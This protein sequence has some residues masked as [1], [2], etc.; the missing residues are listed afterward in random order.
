MKA[1]RFPTN[2]K[3]GYVAGIHKGGDKDIPANYRPIVLTSHIS[4]ILERLVRMDMVQY[5]DENQLWDSR[6]HRS[7]RGRS[8]LSQ[9]LLH[10]DGI[11]QAME[12]GK[13]LVVIY[14][15][16]AKAYDRVDHSVLIGKIKALGFEAKIGEWISTFLI[17]RT[18]S[19]KI[20]GT[21]SEAKMIWSGVPQGSVLG[22]ILFL[23]FIADI[24]MASNAV[25]WIYV[26][27]S[28][29]SMDVTD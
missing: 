27:D 4:K 11:I 14:L 18:Q 25:S 23:I 6:Q 8:T 12:Q 21:L 26:D 9:L 17:E 3:N 13:N 24:G 1:G 19:V 16:F 10:Y 28:K 15:D 20:D 7:R 5:L 2:L 29:V 22:P